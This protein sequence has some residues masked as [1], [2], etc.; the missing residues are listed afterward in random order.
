MANRNTDGLLAEVVAELGELT[1]AESGLACRLLA[2]GLSVAEVIARIRAERER[3]KQIDEPKVDEIEI[4]E[5][6]RERGNYP[7]F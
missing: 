5:P 2:A 7:S 3:L 6:K 4:D 1:D